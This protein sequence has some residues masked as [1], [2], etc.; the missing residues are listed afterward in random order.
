LG[1][2]IALYLALVVRVLLSF[3]LL[4]FGAARAGRRQRGGS[5]VLYLLL[6]L[7]DHTVPEP[8]QEAAGG[9]ESATGADR[10]IPAAAAPQRSVTSKLVHGHTRHTGRGPC[11]RFCARTDAPRSAFAQGRPSAP[12]LL[13]YTRREFPARHLSRLKKRRRLDRDWVVGRD[14]TLQT[15]LEQAHDASR[16]GSAARARQSKWNERGQKEQQM[17]RPPPSPHRVHSSSLSSFHLPPIVAVPVSSPLTPSVSDR[18]AHT[19]GGP[20][21]SNHPQPTTQ[22]HAANHDA[23]RVLCLGAVS[24]RPSI[25]HTAHPT[26]LRE[27]AAGG[28]LPWSDTRACSKIITLAPSPLPNTPHALANPGPLVV[29]SPLALAGN[30]THRPRQTCDLTNTYIPSRASLVDTHSP[31]SVPQRHDPPPPQR[32]TYRACTLRHWCALVCRALY[33]VHVVSQRRSVVRAGVAPK[34]LDALQ[35]CSTR[36][37]PYT[38]VLVQL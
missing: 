33:V 26:G 1:S 15:L 25:G 10:T 13:R 8:N 29:L 22:S 17:R 38:T 36:C 28:P 35:H 11:A 19:E 31:R 5:K 32:A 18:W 4:A 7:H 14:G 27:G 12:Q 24:P 9:G 21:P 30:T 6:A 23:V 20:Q 37:D 34:P 3:G 2:A 16:G